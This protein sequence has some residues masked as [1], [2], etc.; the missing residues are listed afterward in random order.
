MKIFVFIVITALFVAG[1]YSTTQTFFAVTL[2]NQL[3]YFLLTLLLAVD[4]FIFLKLAFLLM[5]NKPK[6]LYKR[7]SYM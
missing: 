6:L 1:G 2:L 4:V 5:K 3:T 7:F